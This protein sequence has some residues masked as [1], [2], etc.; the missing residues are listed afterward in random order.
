M[1]ALEEELVSE[2]VSLLHNVVLQTHILDKWRWIIDPFSGT[3]RAKLLTWGTSYFC[4]E[5]SYFHP[6]SAPNPFLLLQDLI[7]RIFVPER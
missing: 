6:E 1:L 5:S 4:T 3:G 2:C 7:F